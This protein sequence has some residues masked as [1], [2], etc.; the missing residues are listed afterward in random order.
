MFKLLEQYKDEP[1]SPKSLADLVEFEHRA[2]IRGY[3]ESAEYIKSW[4]LFM[5]YHIRAEWNLDEPS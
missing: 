2:R 3:A 1:H 5:E 4:R